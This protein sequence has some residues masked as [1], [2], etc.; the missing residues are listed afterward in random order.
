MSRGGKKASRR[1]F[2]MGSFGLVR[3]LRTALLAAGVAF[4]S[5]CTTLGPDY[6]EPDVEWLAD[7]QTVP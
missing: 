2:R 7:W 6:T 3:T 1:L 4:L 5:A